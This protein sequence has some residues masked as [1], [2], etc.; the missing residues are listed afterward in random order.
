M[1][2]I[3]VWLSGTEFTFDLI[4]TDVDKFRALY[5]T[6]DIDFIY[7]CSSRTFLVNLSSEV[8][9][10]TVMGYLFKMWTGK[11][12]I[13]DVDAADKYIETGLAIFKSRSSDHVF[14]GVTYRLPRHLD[15]L[16]ARVAVI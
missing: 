16:E 5:E 7:D 12:D 4:T 14:V 11:E 1:S 2:E 15:F 13:R 9:H 8:A 3:E 6:C 10:T